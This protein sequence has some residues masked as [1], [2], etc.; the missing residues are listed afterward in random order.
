LHAERLV[1]REKKGKKEHVVAPSREKGK[2]EDPLPALISFFFAWGEERKKETAATAGLR[3]FRLKRRK[4]GK[5]RKNREDPFSPS[6]ILSTLERERGRERPPSLPSVVGGEEGKE[7]GP[8]GYHYLR[9]LS[10]HLRG[11]EEKGRDVPAY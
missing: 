3:T 10:A 7:S 9:L 4:G 6:S 2:G 8:C 5:E 11:G 1:R